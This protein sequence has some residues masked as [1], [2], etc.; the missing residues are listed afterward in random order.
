MVAMAPMPGSGISIIRIM[1][2]MFIIMGMLLIMFIIGMP[3]IPG[4]P[5]GVVGCAGAGA[6]VVLCGWC[7][8]FVVG[9]WAQTKVLVVTINTSAA[10]IVMGFMNLLLFHCPR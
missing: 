1:P 2:I 7:G 5:G 10:A 8:S 4:W 9:A 3:P 6:G